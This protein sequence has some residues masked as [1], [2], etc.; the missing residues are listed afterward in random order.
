LPIYDADLVQ[1]CDVLAQ[2]PRNA[3]RLKQLISAHQGVF[4]TSPEYN[5]SIAPL[6]KNALDWISEAREGA[7]PSQAAYRDRVFALGGASSGSAGTAQSL[8]ALRQVL[9]AG[10]GATVLPEQISVS[11]AEEAFDD[12]DE[13]TDARAAAELKAL[14]RKLVEAATLVARR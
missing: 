5:A 6:V 11:N 2:V 7:E 4:I 13:L 1:S 10:C 9:T 8:L 14:V 12:M 3:V